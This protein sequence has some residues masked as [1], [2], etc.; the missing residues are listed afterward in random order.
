MNEVW[1]WSWSA[2]ASHDVTR[3]RRAG[4]QPANTAAYAA[5]NGGRTSCPLSWKYDVTS[6]CRFR[7]M[8]LIYLKNNPLKFHPSPIWN[9]RALM[10][11]PDGSNVYGSGGGETEGIRS[12][13]RAES[14]EIVFLGGTSYLLV[15]RRMYHLAA[16]QTKHVATETLPHTKNQ[17][18]LYL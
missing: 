4:G 1:I 15:C 16:S 10:Y 12:T 7:K 8:T 6:K 18:P 9:D 2:T 5:S 11:S 13:Y 14:C 3:A 17:T